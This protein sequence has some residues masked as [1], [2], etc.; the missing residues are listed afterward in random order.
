[1]AHSRRSSFP[2]RRRSSWEIGPGGNNVVTTS[3]AAL[4]ATFGTGAQ[5][6]QDGLTLVRIRGF[7]ELILSQAASGGDGYAGALG[8]GIVTGDAAAIGVTAM[9]TPIANEFWDGWVW[10]Q[11]FSLKSPVATVSGNSRQVFEIDSKAMR[12]LRDEDVLFAAIEGTEVGTAT[13]FATLGSRTLVK[14]P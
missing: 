8:I 5:A 12:K 14:L 11:F 6:T 2:A 4:L 3:A 7:A 9:P 1:V 13:I 10:H